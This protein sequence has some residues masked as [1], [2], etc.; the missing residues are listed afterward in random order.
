ML[1]MEKSLNEKFVDTLKERFPQKRQL[2]SVLS[3]M[4]HIEKEAVYRRLKDQIPFIF[5]EIARLGSCFK[6]SLNI[7]PQSLSVTF[8]NIYKFYLL[9]WR[10][11]YDEGS[12]KYPYS[13]IRTSSR[14][15]EVSRRMA[16]AL[17]SAATVYYIWDKMVF[18]HLVNDRTSFANIRLISKEEVKVI[19]AELFRVLSFLEEVAI[20]SSFREQKGKVSAGNGRSLKRY[21]GLLRTAVQVSG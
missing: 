18:R 10:Y 11:Q 4:L 12:H 20:R 1:R 5:L 21:R 17:R 3:Q 14:L 6:I 13:N 15:R 19:R 9:K 2:V 7:L 16:M 8:E